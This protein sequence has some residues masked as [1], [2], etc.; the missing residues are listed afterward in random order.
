MRKDVALLPPRLAM[1]GAMLYH[2]LDKLKEG[3]REGAAQAFH[4]MGIRP[5]HV[6]ARATGITETAVGILS[7]L[8]VLTRPAAIAVLV[9]QA[10]AIAKVHAPKGYAITG[11][12]YEY[13]LALMAIATELLIAGPGRLSLHE[14]IE[15]LVQAGGERQSF[16]SRLVRLLK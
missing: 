13:N 10:V 3:N 5:G 15:G 1:A 2:G 14:A 6:W 4:G 7:L 8:G 12:G 16:V 11:G 9:T